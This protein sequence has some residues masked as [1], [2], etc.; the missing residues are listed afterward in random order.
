MLPIL[1][2]AALP[3]ESAALRRR[4]EVRAVPGRRHL[5]EAE[6]SG[7]SLRIATLGDGRGR[8]VRAL[9][10]LL[11]EQ[12][13]AGV[14][15]IGF[16]GALDPELSVGDLVLAAEI[17]SSTN[18]RVYLTRPALKGVAPGGRVISTLQLAGR[19]EKKRLSQ[20]AAGGAVVVDLESHALAGVA[21]V[22]E[23]PFAVLRIVSDRLDEALPPAI[24]RAQ[25]EDGSVSRLKILG[26]ALL[27]PWEIPGLISMG[28]RASR[29][30]A[31]LAE[32]LV[33][34][35]R[36][37]PQLFADSEESDA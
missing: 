24:V 16:A 7:Q 8:A 25:R 34:A 6:F 22:R 32:A 19:A 35:L 4:L 21:A 29:L 23:L 2:A 36:D 9:E 31:L 1:V 17:A 37:H 10:S 26:S 12:R 15:L 33:S 3:E 27:R 13:Y 18:H 14:L 20:D 5:W 30:S 11:S 28:R